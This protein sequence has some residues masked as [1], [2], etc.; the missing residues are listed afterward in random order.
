MPLTR[1]DLPDP[2]TPVTQT[3]LPRGIS[4]SIC[5]R[6]CSAAPRTVRYP[7]GFRRFAGR[8]K[9]KD[10]NINGGYYET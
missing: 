4:T 6:L 9:N 10:I 7:V 2:D 3:N 1:E 8:G 5:F